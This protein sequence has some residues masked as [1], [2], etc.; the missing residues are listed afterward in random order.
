MILFNLF[1]DNNIKFNFHF[2]KAGPICIF[3]IRTNEKAN[4]DY[5]EVNA[6]T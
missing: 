1:I 2:P 4:D 3:L 5:D 6:V